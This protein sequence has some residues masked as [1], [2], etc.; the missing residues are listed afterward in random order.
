MNSKNH[1]AFWIYGFGFALLAITIALYFGYFQPEWK[2]YQAQ[3]RD[4][5]TSKFGAQKAAAVPPGIQQVWIHDLSRTD[6]C[7]TCHQGM[8]WS[9]LD[10][11]SN[12]FRSHPRKILAKHP[13]SQYGCSICHGG[14]G[15]GTDQ[16][17]AHAVDIDYWGS[18]LLGS[19]L[20]TTYSISDRKAMIETNC[21]VC[22][23]FDRRTEGAPYINDAK[24]LV[25][26]KGCR[27]CH[28]INGRGGVI[29]PDLTYV[30]DK[31]TEQYDY[32]RLSG[33]NSVFAWH[34]AHF[35]DPKAMSQTT[36]MPNFGFG[37]HDAQ[38]LALLVMS[39][40]RA[41]VPV[42]YLPGVKLADTPTPEEQA[43]EQQ[44]LQGEG[45]FFVKKTCFICHDVST[46][47]IE[48]AAKIGP[49]LAKAVTDVPARF[50][51]PLDDFLMS[52]TGTMQMVLATQIQL[53]DDEKR[54]AIAKLKVANQKLVEQAQEN[55]S[56]TL[57]N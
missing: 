8:E 35:K 21:N 45:A 12:P 24:E 37:S 47:G 48:S 52:P 34:L 30:G 16:A 17:S 25:S 46:L 28:K 13:I 19:E 39:W 27:A 31:S 29:G 55:K 3:F 26:K 23:R 22:H 10:S 11:V 56:T 41:N 20:A 38:A 4:L 36:V 33:V 2:D 50:G 42:E 1:D 51:R 14:Q 54:E 6:R 40:R 5:V 57:K 53:T 49:D 15:Y 9:G 44:M 7:V 18:P 32:S 43:K